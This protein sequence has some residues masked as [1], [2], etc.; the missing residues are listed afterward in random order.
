M[1]V[2]DHVDPQLGEHRFDNWAERAVF[3]FHPVTPTATPAKPTFPR[4]VLSLADLFHPKTIDTPRFVNALTEHQILVTNALLRIVHG[5]WDVDETNKPLSGFNEK[6][7]EDKD[8]WIVDENVLVRVH[9]KARIKFFDPRERPHPKI[10]VHMLQDERKTMRVDPDSNE[11]SDGGW[12]L[13]EEGWNCHTDNWRT[14]GCK[15]HE[16]D[17]WVG[18]TIFKRR[19]REEYLSAPAVSS[20]T[21]KFIPKDDLFVAGHIS[22]IGR[23][24][25]GVGSVHLILK[26]VKGKMDIHYSFESCDEDFML[27]YMTYGTNKN[28]LRVQPTLMNVEITMYE[29]PQ[30]T[31]RLV[32]LC[33]EEVNW[34]TI[35]NAKRQEKY[36]RRE[37][38]GD[39][40]LLVITIT[41]HD[42][43]N[44]EYGF[45]KASHSV[46]NEGDSIFFSGPCTGGSS[47]SRLNRSRSPETKEKIEAKVLIFEQ[48]WKRFELLFTDVYPKQVGIH[49]EL[50]RG[51][52][53]WNNKDVKFLIEGTD[54]TIHDF[55][56]CCYGLRQK[57]GDTSKYI[58]KPW[59]IVSWNIDIG[60]RLSLKCDGRHEHAPCA[61]R[62]TVHTQIYTSKIVSIIIEEQIRRVGNMKS[63][64]V[65]NRNTGS[66][67]HNVKKSGVAAACVARDY[68]FEGLHS[69][70][71]NGKTNK[72]STFIL[73]ISIIFR[74]NLRS[75]YLWDPPLI[76]K[77]DKLS[78]NR[79]FRTTGAGRTG[80]LDG[81]KSCS[82]AMAASGSDSRPFRQ[83]PSG[84]KQDNPTFYKQPLFALGNETKGTAYLRR[85]GAT[86]KALIEDENRGTIVL[87][88]KFGD[89]A[90]SDS[91]PFQWASFG[92]PLVLLIGLALGRVATV[93]QAKIPLFK[94]LL[95][96][97]RE[98]DLDLPLGET[99]AK[100]VKQCAM[101]SIAASN[102]IS[103]KGRGESEDLHSVEPILDKLATTSCLNEIAAGAQNLSDDLIA[104]N[105]GGT[106]RS[107]MD[108]GTGTPQRSYLDRNAPLYKTRSE[109][110]HLIFNF[111]A[112]VDPPKGTFHAITSLEHMAHHADQLLRELSLNIRIYNKE[113]QTINGKLSISGVVDDIVRH[114][115]RSTAAAAFVVPPRAAAMNVVIG[116]AALLDMMRKHVTHKEKFLEAQLM[117]YGVEHK[118]KCVRSPFWDHFDELIKNSFDWFGMGDSFEGFSFDVLSVDNEVNWAVNKK[119]SIIGA[120]SEWATNVKKLDTLN[121][122][123]GTKDIPYEFDDGRPPDDTDTT[124]TCGV[125]D[126]RVIEIG[127]DSGPGSKEQKG[128]S[129]T[130]GESS[131]VH[132][133]DAGFPKRAPPQQPP[134]KQS[135]QKKAHSNLRTA[136][137]PS[138]AMFSH[139]SMSADEDENV[140]LH[141]NEWRFPE[142]SGRLIKAMKKKLYGNP[143]KD[144]VIVTWVM[145][146]NPDE[147][148]GAY[149]E[150][151]VPMGIAMSLVGEWEV[152]LRRTTI[153]LCAWCEGIVPPKVL[154][155]YIGRD[156]RNWIKLYRYIWLK[157]QSNHLTVFPSPKT[158]ALATCL[159]CA[160]DSDVR[161][162]VIEETTLPTASIKD[163]MQFT[164]IKSESTIIVSDLPLNWKSNQK[165]LNDIPRTAEAWGWNQLTHYSPE[166]YDVNLEYLVQSCRSAAN[167]LQ[168]LGPEETARRATIHV[169]IA[170]IDIVDYIG[171]KSSSTFTTKDSSHEQVKYFMNCLDLLSLEKTGVNP[172]VINING[173]G[174]FVCCRDVEKF[175]RVSK[176]VATELR[177]AGYM[178]SWNGPM[179]REIH[180][181]LDQHGRLKKGIG[182]PE[183][184]LGVAV[185]E[186][187]L[188]REKVLFKCMI[189]Q[190]EQQKLDHLATQSGIGAI[191]GLLDDPPDEFRFEEVNAIPLASGLKETR[192][193]KATNKNKLHVPNWE[194]ETKLS[195]V[196]KLVD[197]GKYFWHEISNSMMIIDDDDPMSMLSGF[198][199][200][201]ELRPNLD[202]KECPNNKSCA[203]CSANYT[204]RAFGSDDSK[205]VEMRIFLAHRSQELYNSD[206][207]WVSF[208]VNKEL[209]GFIEAT[210]RKLIDNNIGKAISQYGFIRM[211]PSAAAKLLASDRG[212]LIVTTR[213]EKTETSKTYFRFAYDMGNKLYAAFMHA[214]FSPEFIMEVFA[215]PDPKEEKLGDAVELVLGL[216][217]V[218]D[219]VPQCIPEN[220]D[221]P[222]IINQ[223]RRGFENSL[224]HFC[225]TSSVKV[226]SQNRK[227]NKRPKGIRE[228]IPSTIDGVEKSIN[229]HVPDYEA[230]NDFS[231]FSDIIEDAL[232]HEDENDDPGQDPEKDEK[233]EED[234]QMVI[235]SEDEKMEP[236][237]KDEEEEQFGDR[238]D[239]DEDESLPEAKR[240][241]IAN[242]IR[243]INSTAAEDNICLACG[244]ADHSINSCP[245][246]EAKREVS[247]ALQTLL[248]RFNEPSTSP[249]V[250]SSPKARKSSSA[251]GPSRQKPVDPKP[252]RVTVSYPSELSMLDRCANLQG[253]HWTI[254]GT[255]TKVV[256]PSS[257]YEVVDNLVP[258]MDED[259][260][261]EI[262]ETQQQGP[263]EANLSNKLYYVNIREKHPV[264]S[265]R[266]PPIDGVR[267]YHPDFDNADY[268]DSYR[269]RRLPKYPQRDSPKWKAGGDLNKMLRHCIARPNQ[270]LTGDY[271]LK[272]DEGAWVLIDDIVQY[273]H[274]WHDGHNFCRALDDDNKVLANTIRLQ[275][276]GWIVDLAV[277]ESSGKGKVRFQIQALRATNHE[278]VIKLCGQSG[279]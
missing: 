199:D 234:E 188:W 191:E 240:R 58:K 210:I 103:R 216:F 251:R 21:V 253:G 128:A 228:E 18:R 238:M 207:E 152:L 245:N 153:Y 83:P 4:L 138:P 139:D 212:H 115:R 6:A 91:L 112:S 104:K 196:P 198:C 114:Y 57:F 137:P 232:S 97:V 185:M 267:Y 88:P 22:C 10:P 159:D 165:I 89:R 35:L 70:A 107:L 201:C 76:P 42:D 206:P 136:T 217:D 135:S 122:G 275:R 94:T 147:A 243:S 36:G 49:M 12:R 231:P 235:S 54:S 134:P 125:K 179:W 273:D 195:A 96:M 181:F 256:G 221:G 250:S 92:I 3:Q 182:L 69:N 186:K 166:D 32:L 66:S 262:R 131:K 202:D 120:W 9:K 121:P 242:M 211:H 164:G 67:G 271:P 28:P 40:S 172:I 65:S 252:E 68:H 178:V 30:E 11:E 106:L 170:M 219:S 175:Q 162:K 143:N 257:H 109:E 171:S 278:E 264:G 140:M 209:M 43:L 110:W 146:H 34:F 74:T 248:M 156:N 46:R 150:S 51:C 20:E 154:R 87:P 208:N 218:W 119:D 62:E 48:L 269:D 60:N 161:K 2:E 52:L 192:A 148:A 111:Y 59:R 247:D 16:D 204:L 193:P 215:T 149:D 23:T 132:K 37:G 24:G 205:D 75:R 31:P 108:R 265:L 90:P 239:I 80:R 85:A 266:C 246:P 160:A 174:E 84:R 268:L 113:H 56:G 100:I 158:F 99:V 38:V 39:I 127:S 33:S 117:I 272:C 259:I 133:S 63:E 244:S 249:K 223:M 72:T 79:G 8:Y 26:R 17:P 254:L 233:E 44:S 123:T 222:E 124:A 118:Q 237:E 77:R 102:F 71:N 187:Q 95:Q 197:D 168:Q 183:K 157:S 101:M 155:K 27:L 78:P 167:V 50:P 258:E 263:S 142:P 141:T 224:L 14:G 241:K 184:H 276:V 144:I 64:N 189:N 255:E 47:W 220:F 274:I 145:K 5:G 29:I 230:Q 151:F 55:D 45:K 277:T 19:K 61:G 236:D 279:Y 214:M 270:R 25:G 190:D 13:D 173:A 176:N 116:L 86:L 226:G 81:Q 200:V 261:A 163:A 180:P 129:T 82:V 227:I 177:A 15:R 130:A 7:K 169:W 53:Y 93:D 203:N 98:S 260:E 225:S 194:D 126:P 105:L 73:R 41:I 1:Q 229:F 213:F